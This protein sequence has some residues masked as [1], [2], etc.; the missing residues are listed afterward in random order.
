MKII[1]Y[2]VI[3]LIFVA[4]N[5]LALTPEEIAET[6]LA[7][8]ALVSMT[9]TAGQSYFGSGFVIGDGQI[10]TNY[11]VIE[12]IASGTVQLVGETTKH[13]IISVIASDKSHDLAI[14]EVTGVSAP[15]LALGDSDIVQVGQ[16]VFVLGNPQGLTGTFS[17]GVISAI[18]PEGNDLVEDRLLQITAPISPGSSGGPVLNDKGEVIGIAFAQVSRGQNLNFAIPVNNLKTLLGIA[19]GTELNILDPNLLAALRKALNKTLG[20]PI[21]AND[22]TTLT[23]LSARWNNIK[24]LKGLEFA[25]NLTSLNLYYNDVTDLSPLAGLTHLETLNLAYNDITDLSSLAGLTHLETLN[26]EDNDITD[27]SP[28]SRLINLRSLNLWDN[29]IWDISVLKGLTHIESLFLGDNLIF[30]LSPLVVNTGLGTGD[31]IDLRQSHA[32]S[33]TAVNTHI[34]ALRARGVTVHRTYLYFSGPQIVNVGQTVTLNFNVR[35]TADLSRLKLDIKIYTTDLS[36]VSVAEE[37]F[38]KQNG[39]PT[40]FTEGIINETDPENVKLE[41]IEIIRLDKSGANGSGVLVSTIFRGNEIGAGGVYFDAEILTASGEKILHSEQY[42]HVLEVVASWDINR[43]GV[44]N[45]LDLEIV[46]QKIGTYDETADLNGDEYVSVADFVLVAAHL[47]ESVTNDAPGSGAI[48]SVPNA[49]IQRWLDMVHE[50]DDGSAMFQKGIVNLESLL[51][52]TY[53]DQTVLLPNYPNPFNPETWIPYHLAV[54]ADVTLTIYDTKGIMVRQLDLGYQQA[55]Y[56]TDRTRAAYWDGRNNLGE[57]VGSGIYFLS[58]AGVFISIYRGRRFFRHPKVG[59][60][61]M[62]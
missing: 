46:A 40:F 36:I 3:V 15:A 59:H 48:T 31:V 5:A 8:T 21:T 53:P 24:D 52:A 12:G 47:G 54:D 1:F 7:S 28:L 25:T 30:D 37:D 34:P 32:L 16:S 11:H 62:N 14:I 9:N 39:T 27:L 44:V 2:T 60:P 26:L 13:P 10:A 38:L 23:S 29:R 51:K 49:I 19:S 6:A 35:D 50:A 22:M 57:T 41:G 61:E 42:R 43:D 18:R 56:Y 55:G 33:E 20:S 17:T 58:V 4:S 45:A